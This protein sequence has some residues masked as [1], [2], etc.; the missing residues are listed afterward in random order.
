MNQDE[1]I[2][3]AAKYLEDLLSFFGINVAVY[4]TID[5]EVIQLSVPSTSLNSLL[6]G[7]NADNLRAL[8]H[9]VSMAL[10]AK[11][12]EITRVNV[13][14]AN[15]KRQRADRIEEKAEGWIAKVRE[16]G[17]PMT[18]NLNAA[19]RRVVHKLAQDYSDIETHSEGEGR[20]RKLIIS[21]VTE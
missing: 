11:N 8:Q 1:S 20:E 10:N 14:V 16:T 21:K 17:E 4:S 15:Y 3:F 5:D 7:R 18:I 9:I 19:D 12:A 6:I 2:R 13:D